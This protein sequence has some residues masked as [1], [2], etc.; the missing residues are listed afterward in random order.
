RH[1][2]HPLGALH[3]QL[4]AARLLG[5]RSRDLL[6][7]LGDTPDRVGDLLRA[8]RLFDG[9]AGD[10]AHHVGRLLARLEDLLEG[11]LGLV[12][13]LDAAVDVVRAALD[14]RDRVAALPLHRLD[15]IGDLPRARARALGEVLDLV[16][17]DGEALALLA[18][19]RGD[20]G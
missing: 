4:R 16:S 8:L 18:G 19:L 9:R 13:D 14:G 15:Q 11:A 12:R 10:R 7:G 5:R 3:D 6:D 2:A 17:D 20:D 1:E